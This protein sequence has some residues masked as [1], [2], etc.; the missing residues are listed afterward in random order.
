MGTTADLFDEALFWQPVPVSPSHTSRFFHERATKLQA[1]NQKIR[2]FRA[3]L[4]LLA[5]LLT[6][7]LERL[8]IAASFKRDFAILVLYYSFAF[9]LFA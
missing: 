8:V 2:A 4:N 6:L 3:R 7:I 5:K 1:L 9:S